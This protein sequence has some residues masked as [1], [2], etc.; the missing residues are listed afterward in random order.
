MQRQVGG[1][2]QVVLAVGFAGGEREVLA[3][4][5]E[6]RLLA[7]NLLAAVPEWM[8]KEAAIASLADSFGAAGAMADVG[9]AFSQATLNNNFRTV[10]D[11]VDAILAALR[12]HGLLT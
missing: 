6:R 7:Y 9:A 11:K 3:G 4:G 10:S 5:A 12:A 2:G 1:E 8:V